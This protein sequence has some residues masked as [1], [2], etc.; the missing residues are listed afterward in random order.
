MGLK[1]NCRDTLEK[2]CSV[3]LVKHNAKTSI[4]VLDRGLNKNGPSS[5]VTATSAVF[6]K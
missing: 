2:K 3:I 1:L 4:M 5:R 6:P